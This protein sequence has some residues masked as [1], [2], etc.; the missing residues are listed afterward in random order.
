MANINKKNL[1]LA[2]KQNYLPS[3][4]NKSLLFFD[5]VTFSYKNNNSINSIN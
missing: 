4:H 2:K 5:Q 3:L 1:L